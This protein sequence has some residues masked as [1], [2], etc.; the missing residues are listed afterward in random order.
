MSLSKTY[1]STMNRAL[2]DTSTTN[3]VASSTL[4]A[5]KEFLMGGISGTNGPEGARPSSAYWTLVQCTDSVTVKTDGTD[6][7]GG[8]AYDSTKWVRNTAGNAH[9][10]F[11][12]KSPT[13][14]LDQPWYF[15]VDWAGA[16]DQIATFV[17]TKTLPSGGTT[18][19]RPTSTVEATRANIF[20]EASANAA[21]SHFITDAN[22]NFWFL[23]SRNGQ[24][25]FQFCAMWQELTEARSSGDTGRAVALF[26][27]AVV[28]GGAL[29][30]VNNTTGLNPISLTYNLVA[31]STTKI[32]L[33][34]MYGSAAAA[35]WNVAGTNASD[36]KVD[37]MPIFYVYDQLAGSTGVRGRM[38]DI[39][40]TGRQVAVGSVEPASGTPVTVCV[41]SVWIPCS[42]APSL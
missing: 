27:Q 42:V 38:A 39:F 40:V 26:S 20:A 13:G 12:L 7:L 30:Y 11:V 16:N 24:G 6:L 5:L 4:F 25:Y 3:K 21:K 8:A 32:L 2:D 9:T 1:Y 29:D 33:P 15:T 23:E 19:A 17:L 18:T 41:G 37:S 34:Q 28:N 36:A 35:A 22:G 14:M 31:A 10:W